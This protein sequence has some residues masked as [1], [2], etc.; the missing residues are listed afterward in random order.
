MIIDSLRKVLE[1]EATK[2]Y[3]DKAVIGGLDKYLHRQAGQIRQAVSSPRLGAVFDRL[4]LAESNYGSWDTD[5]R[6]KWIAKLLSW[7]DE[8]EKTTEQALS[9]R[10]RRPSPVTMT[11]ELAPPASN[12]E[13]SR[14]LHQ[15]RFSGKGQETLDSPITVIRGITEKVAA[16]FAKLGVTTIS[17][18]LYFTPRRYIDY[19]QRSPIAEL[20][21]DTEQTIKKEQTIIGSVWE[22]RVKT[23]GNRPG[24]EVTV[25]DE[26]GTVRAVWF[27][28]PY[29][30]RNFPTNTRIVLSGTVAEFR[31][32]KV[33][34]SPQWE[35][36]T[37]QELIHTGRLVPI[38][39]LTQGLYP[40]QV[41]KW[42]KQVT[43][44]LL[45][46]LSD[47]L[48]QGIS[49]RCDLLELREAIRQ[50]HYPDD[51]LMAQ[52][53]RERLA[54]DELLLFQLGVLARKRDW[55][56]GQPGNA[57]V[58]RREVID[59]FLARLPFTLTRAQER[60][61]EDILA[62]LRQARAMSRLLQGEVG[63]GK[64]V[65]ATL[66]LLTAVANGFQGAFMAPTEILAEQH[67]HNICSYLAKTST[68]DNRPEKHGDQ[69]TSAQSSHIRH[70]D[71]FLSRPLA[72]ALLVGSL[73]DQE[74]RN[75]H[76]K[77]EQGEIDIAIGTHA[78]IQKEVEFRRLGLAVIDEQQRFGVLQRSALRQKGFNPHVLV[79]TATPIPRT[80]ALT[81]YG[82]LDLSVIDELPPGRQII[83]TEYL[84]PQHVEKAYA[85]LRQQ[86]SNGKQ[87]FII[88]PLIEE[89]EALE[90]KA[91]TSE[92]EYLSTQVFP[93]LK[94]GLLHGR[95]HPGDKE[96]VMRRFRDGELD[97]LVSTSVVEVGIDIPT[98]TVMLI[99][100]AD[101]F[102]LSQ[103]HQ[104]RG[105]VGR[106]K[107]QS[108]CLLIPERAAVEAPEASDRLRLM[109]NIHDGFVLAQKDLDLRGP[110]QF[111]G[112][113]QS[114]LPELK[115]AKLSNLRLLELA[116]HEAMILF[117]SD[118]SLRKADH[119][120]LRQR[121]SQLWPSSIEWS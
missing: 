96:Q 12:P 49:R 21:A 118:H 58:I 20:E 38:Y 95:M 39:P 74:K 92:H 97:I 6:K 69:A 93:D 72:I 43:D 76:H 99:E 19:S 8:L 44:K 91:A 45:W 11:V 36:L 82:D 104:F 4:N 26:S 14:T 68:L 75:L 101:H 10:H 107:D 98:A 87:A 79:M 112:T 63:S 53:A 34:Q 102:G 13:E 94:L 55:Q 70:Y 48:P 56:E 90:A 103:L 66:T 5:Q 117:Q 42:T 85:F 27:N 67:F 15:E 41:R 100:G 59:G 16:R 47:F 78:L 115:I 77:I 83:R 61:L 64:T 105:R 57:F 62:D 113:Q 106:G 109:E 2:G 84:E 88:C 89:S 24:T 18:L 37:D 111:F 32:K 31:G 65:V 9:L 28:Q 35:L 25:A 17:D 46:Q 51:Q 108:Y 52:K 29:L 119:G 23:F 120:P 81:L 116:R 60:V 1:L 30:A 114:G 54:F 73:S 7:L 86:V 40:R 110:G 80:L 3:S 71:G 33:F 121:L 50:A 22:S